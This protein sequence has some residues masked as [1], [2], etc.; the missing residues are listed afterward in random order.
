[1][2]FTRWFTKGLQ[3]GDLTVNSVCNNFLLKFLNFFKDLS[4]NLFFTKEAY[5]VHCKIFSKFLSSIRFFARHYF[6][7]AIKGLCN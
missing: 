1:M 6:F 3:K 7:D 5:Y 2:W 4:V